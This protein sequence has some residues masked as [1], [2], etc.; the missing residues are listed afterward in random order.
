MIKRADYG[1]DFY[2][3]RWWVGTLNTSCGSVIWSGYPFKYVTVIFQFRR[4]GATLPPPGIDVEGAYF[5]WFEFLSAAREW[6]R[7]SAGPYPLPRLCDER[8][9]NERAHDYQV[10]GRTYHYCDEHARAAGF[11]LMCGSFIAGSNDDTHKGYCTD[12]LDELA[13]DYKDYDDF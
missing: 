13:E 8:G 2:L 3:F 5:E 6:K 10:D 7:F 12:C 11:C 4:L 1:W 9:C